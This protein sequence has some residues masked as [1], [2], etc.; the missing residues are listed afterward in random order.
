MPTLPKRKKVEHSTAAYLNDTAIE[1][2]LRR[3]ANVPVDATDVD[4]WR[5]ED[6]MYGYTVYWRRLETDE[7][8]DK[9]AA[10]YIKNADK[11][12]ASEEKRKARLA[13]QRRKDEEQER[14]ELAR[15]K[16]KYGP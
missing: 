9:R 13:E 15:L 11:R 8:Y 5:D 14:K 4:F 7:E 10:K 16:A 6:T 12:K 3:E 1:E 2:M